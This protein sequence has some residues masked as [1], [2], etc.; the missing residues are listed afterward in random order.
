M[1]STLAKVGRPVVFVKIR[2]LSSTSFAAAGSPPT[3]LPLMK[4]LYCFGVKAW[5][6]SSP[7]LRAIRSALREPRGWLTSLGLL[8]TRGADVEI[9]VADALATANMPSEIAPGVIAYAMQDVMDR[10]RPAYFDDW[11]EFSRAALAVNRERLVDYIAAQAAGGPLLPRRA[12][13]GREH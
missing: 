1:P 6:L 9:L 4:S 7:S 13:D 10:A 11:P 5:R 3:P 12:P 2:T 8:A